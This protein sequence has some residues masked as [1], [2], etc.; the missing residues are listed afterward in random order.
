MLWFHSWK[1]LNQGLTHGSPISEPSHTATGH[2][3]SPAL[4]I[5]S[6]PR[7]LLKILPW[8]PSASKIKSK[9]PTWYQFLSSIRPAIVLSGLI[10]SPRSPASRSPLLWP[11]VIYSLKSYLMSTYCVPD[12]LCLLLLEKTGCEE[13]YEETKAL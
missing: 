3:A 10:L 13:C 5:T 8:L 7:T 6:P 2:T 11:F 1:L 12:T 9:C 4:R